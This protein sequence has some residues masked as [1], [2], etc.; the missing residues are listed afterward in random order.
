[1]EVIDDKSN[2]NEEN[3]DF[4]DKCDYCG[5]KQEAEEIE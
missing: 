2:T 3:L 4:S 5:R 1:M